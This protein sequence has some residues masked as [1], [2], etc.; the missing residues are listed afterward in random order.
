MCSFTPS[1]NCY[2]MA[3]LSKRLRKTIVAMFDAT[4]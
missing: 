1:S 3:A 4:K 2:V